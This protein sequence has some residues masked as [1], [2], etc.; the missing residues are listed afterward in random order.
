MVMLLVDGYWK[1][2][3]GEDKY[4]KGEESFKWTG[5]RNRLIKREK[6]KKKEKKKKLIERESL[7]N[8]RRNEKSATAS[9]YYK[10]AKVNM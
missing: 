6:E 4:M 5:N 10:R 1:A 7:F 2:R 9:V 3:E 8:E